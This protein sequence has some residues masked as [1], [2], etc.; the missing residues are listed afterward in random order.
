MVHAPKD[1][2]PAGET[3]GEQKEEPSR[4][5]VAQGCLITLCLIGLGVGITL[6]V[7][8]GRPAPAPPETPPSVAGPLWSPPLWLI[9]YWSSEDDS[10]LAEAEPGVVSVV[11][12]GAGQMLH[13]SIQE[14]SADRGDVFKM[15]ASEGGISSS[16]EWGADLTRRGYRGDSGQEWAAQALNADGTVAIEIAFRPAGPSAVVLTVTVGGAEPVAV[17][18]SRDE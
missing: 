5:A 4:K 12:Y 10:F 17:Q 3:Q 6:V 2:A 13:Y 8:S 15:T 7:T 9:G 11:A 1:E 18:L 16:G 14:W